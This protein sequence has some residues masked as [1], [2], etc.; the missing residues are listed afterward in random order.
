[1]LTAVWGPS[2]WHALHTISFNYPVAPTKADKRRY[3]VF[4]ESLAHV[5]PCGKCR[6]NLA[7]Y[8]KKHPL[9]D[10]CL[11]SRRTFSLYVYRLHEAV[12]KLLKKASGLSYC[13]VR[14]LY[15][16]F[17]ARCADENAAHMF[18]KRELGGHGCASPLNGK[19]AKCVLSIV[20]A[21]KR[22]KSMSV[23]AKCLGRRKNHSTQR[24]SRSP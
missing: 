16:H 3:K 24:I 1:M 18:T 7:V 4:M 14:D 19:K 5:L 20:P 21:T 8:Y 12:N 23:D 11:E 13:D 6:A 22:C 2:M 10:R 17:R 9:T 15:E